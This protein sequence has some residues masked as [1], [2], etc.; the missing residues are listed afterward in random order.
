MNTNQTTINQVNATER[1]INYLLN[2]RTQVSSSPE[3]QKITAAK[4]IPFVMTGF[5]KL[6][7]ITDSEAV[8]IIK[9]IS[10]ADAQAI[11][12]IMK[13]LDPVDRKQLDNVLNAAL[14]ISRTADGTDA[15]EV[16]MKEVEKINENLRA[17][18][19]NYTKTEEET[20][21]LFFWKK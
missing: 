9:R 6:E 14:S 10:T 3:S 4:A 2:D 19:H 12:E 8:E 18:Q 7:S 13:A 16:R 17:L 1:G 21:R 11:L 20:S 15:Q 5:E